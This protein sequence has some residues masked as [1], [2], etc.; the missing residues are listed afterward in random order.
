MGGHGIVSGYR[1]DAAGRVEPVLL[2]ARNDAA[3]AWGRRLY[4]SALYAFCAALDIYRGLA[5]LA[6]ASDPPMGMAMISGL[7][8]PWPP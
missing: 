8:V 3:E 2:A 6:A 5:G 7:T 4:R 1:A